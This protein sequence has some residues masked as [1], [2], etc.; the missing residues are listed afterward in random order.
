MIDSMTIPMS[1]KN[2]QIARLINNFFLF[3]KLDQFTDHTIRKAKISFIADY[4]I[5]YKFDNHNLGYVST[6]FETITT[7]CKRL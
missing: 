5:L 1:I 6:K 7:Y 4:Q 2:D 3:P